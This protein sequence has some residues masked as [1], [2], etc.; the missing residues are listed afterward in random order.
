MIGIKEVIKLIKGVSATGINI[1][2]PINTVAQILYNI[3][4]NIKFV[5]ALDWLSK[6]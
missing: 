2:Q 4:D 3:V 5:V 1:T 6:L